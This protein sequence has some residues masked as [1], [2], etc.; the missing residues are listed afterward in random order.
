MNKI[1]SKRILITGSNDGLITLIVPQ[2]EHR[3]FVK[4]FPSLKNLLS[5]VLI[6]LPSLKSKSYG[7]TSQ[8]DLFKNKTEGISVKSILPSL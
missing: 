5:S 3:F 7:N 2:Q 4:I 8:D 6:T 1:L